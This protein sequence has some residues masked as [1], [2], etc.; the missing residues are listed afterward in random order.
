MFLF[1]VWIIDTH[2]VH[3]EL[4]A[5]S[6]ARTNLPHAAM[7][8][9][10]LLS[11]CTILLLSYSCWVFTWLLHCNPFLALC[12]GPDLE[13]RSS[14]PEMA[15]KSA[16]HRARLKNPWGGFPLFYSMRRHAWTQSEGP[17]EV[18]GS[19]HVQSSVSLWHHP[20]VTFLPV[21]SVCA[22]G[23]EGGFA[24]GYL[25]TTLHMS[26]MGQDQG[27]RIPPNL[28]TPGA[29]GSTSIQIALVH[30]Q[31]LSDNGGSAIDGLDPVHLCPAPTWDMLYV[32]HADRH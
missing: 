7:N 21:M 8:C 18:V 19:S 22:F 12:S 3:F 24:C 13:L 32:W 23:G 30:M 4:P 27:S 26:C 11:L 9:P 15:T 17:Q 29:S 25:C 20:E 5:A 31:R 1:T 14:A 28:H 6:C 10:G 2:S 16:S